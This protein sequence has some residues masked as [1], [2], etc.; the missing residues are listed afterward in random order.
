M[1]VVSV[2]FHL[3]RVPRQWYTCGLFASVIDLGALFRLNVTKTDNYEP[4]DSG[5]ILPLDDDNELGLAQLFSPGLFVTIGI[6]E[7]VRRIA[8]EEKGL[9]NGSR[10]LAGIPRPLGGFVDANDQVFVMLGIAI[11]VLAVV[12]F[13]VER[14][15]RSPWGRVL[16]ALR[17]DELATAAS[18]KNV[19]GFKSQSFV[20]GAMI[21]GVGGALY[22]YAF[23]A[24]SPNDFTHFSATF[25][26][27]AMLMVGGS[28]NNRGA[29]LGAYIVW[30][31]WSVTLQ[32]QGYDLPGALAT[33]IVHIRGLVLGLLIVA[34]L[35]L[36]PQ[37]LLPEE[38]R[39]SIWVKRL[40]RAA[41]RAEPQEPA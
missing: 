37:G 12:F 8:I 6:A 3:R 22:A 5:D 30:G 35:L 11:V 7:L 40:G 36:R 2:G 10:G 41:T 14:G 23:S 21:M 15:I 17:E 28:G 13:A 25:L 33:R 1:P 29:I 27:W 24:L 20:L 16:R 34:V 39:V 31:F 26:F 38:R 4:N 18:G 19:F 9:V 32:L